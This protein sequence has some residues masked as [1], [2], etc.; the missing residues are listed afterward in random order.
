MAVLL[1]DRTYGDSAE[2][3]IENGMVE[4]SFPENLELKVLI[5]YVGKR[6]NINFL[7]D[8]QQVSNKRVTIKAPQKLPA[9]SLITLLES[10]LKIKGMG[11]F[12]TEVEGMMSIEASRPLTAISIGP[13]EAEG[14]SMDLRSTSAVTGVFELKHAKPARVNEVIKPF[15]SGSTASIT[16][17]A[18][19]DLVIVTD[20]ASN[21]KRL[22][23]LMA[24]VDRP[25]REVQIR[26][27]EINNNEATIITKSATQLLT[28][29]SNAGGEVGGKNSTIGKIY[30]DERTNRVAVVGSSDE[31]NEVTTLIQLLD[32]P[33]GF[34]TKIYTFQIA[35]P[36]RVD[37]LVKNLIGKPAAKRLYNSQVD[38]QANLL[39]ATTTPEIHKQIEEIRQKVDKPIEDSHSPIRFYKLENAKAVNILATLQTIE[40]D[41]GLGGV[42]VDGVSDRSVQ[43]DSQIAIKGLAEAEMNRPGIFGK[44]DVS[45]SGIFDKS[46]ELRDARIMADE[47]SNTI[48]VIANPSMH[49]VY[50]KL[51]KRLDIR[52]PQVLIKA[53]IVAIDTT[54][55]FELGV[56]ISRSDDIYGNEGK[57]LNFSSF[58]LSTV[59]ANTGGLTLRPGVGFNG[60]MLSADIADVVIHA[61]E[62]DSRVKVVSRPSLLINDNATGTLVSENE[63]PY[64]SVNA[65][66][67]VATTSFAGYSSAGTK[68]LV[69]PQISEGEHLKLEYEITLSSFDEDV[70][71]SLPPS[72]KTNSLKSE[73][74]IPNGSTIVVGGLTR[75]DFINVVDRV[76]LLG[77]IPVLEYLFS[78]RTTHKRKTTLFVFINSV[79]LRDDKFKNLKVLSGDAERLAEL[80]ESYP[81]SEPVEI[82]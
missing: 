41:K 15:L 18:E 31:V 5:D 75:E 42:S 82:Q 69:T 46:V 58:G 35:S 16:T 14:S 81:Y 70:S 60:A 34:E 65:S 17:L 19:H 10:V 36:E 52:R 62:S 61:L 56:E 50:E 53:T 3:S 22:E 37:R 38:E 48:I 4:L 26:F 12:R 47:R 43:A 30:A 68:I 13:K 20:Y 21:M 51:I 27:V 67:T 2:E 73:V 28:A 11:I 78:N 33:L 39:I 71:E 9:K 44:S 49:L 63:E 24:I 77:N 59:D 55:D 45:K 32:V 23:E 64:S 79:I 25:L 40:G 74:T 80:S 54:D 57:V 29:K 72:R 8:E 7:Y 76:P 6:L 66:T 1:C